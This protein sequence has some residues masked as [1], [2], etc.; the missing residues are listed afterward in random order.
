MNRLLREKSP[1]LRM[2]G[3]NPVDWYPWGDEAF[4]AARAQDMPVFL[5]IGYSS[6]HWCH[7]IAHESFEDEAV[8]AILNDGYISVKVDKEE[9]PDVDAV[10]M[11]AVQL[12]TGSGGW[13][14]TLL[15]T[16][17]G[18]PFF[19]AT[20][21][22][23][24]SRDGM[25][26]LKEL[27]LEVRALWQSNR[28]AILRA[29]G[30]FSLRMNELAER[31]VEP[32]E[33]S[34]AL[35][36]RAVRDFSDSYDGRWGGF[37]RAPKFPSAPNLLFL[38]LRGERAGDRTALSLA[39]GTLTAMYRGGLFD[40]VGGGFCRYSVDR[41][42]LIPHFEKMLYD[43]ALLLWAYAEA[44]RVTR[45]PVYRSV[46][47]R[48]AAYVLREMTGP[49]GE[50][51]CAQDADSAGREGAYY[52][53]TPDEIRSML[54]A[55]DGRRFCDWYGITS[56]G[57]FE[58]ESVP[59]LLGNA[60]FASEPDDLAQQRATVYARRR[61]RLPLNRDDKVLTAWNALM[62][63]A[64]CE[65][66][67]AL[68]RPDYRQAACRAEA[69]LRDH[70]V[71]DDGSLLLRYRDGEAR[72]EGVLSDSASYALALAELFEAT[73][74]RAYL[75]RAEAV[76]ADM[77]AHFGSREADGLYLYSDRGE[78]LITRPRDVWDAAMPS[79]NSCAAL[80]LWKLARHTG[81]PDW[82]RAADRQLRFV[83]GAADAH[84]T[85]YGFG[86]LAIV[87]ALQPCD[88]APVDRAARTMEER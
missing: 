1:Y 79:G 76:A 62:I 11:D 66:S 41:K 52:T 43:N 57:N 26:G 38:L 7:V 33:P 75:G 6:C 48:T 14:M 74:D 32:R 5:S 24:E 80:A 49:S 3:E 60:A 65:A 71:R 12:A 88:P 81:A 56:E 47:E 54:G 72:G 28:P 46:A 45:N 36:A 73:G 39:E 35:L 42:W 64:L 53:F 25:A 87:H 69:F 16:P 15:T 55:A 27:L 59:N 22:P 31:P 68:D 21:L 40:H 20:Y 83:A 2:H 13:P 86:L 63:A 10:Y 34:E 37:G 61:E 70:L 44:W 84:P 19:A 82:R 67:R 58:G 78:R 17:D 50:F 18:T 4:A 23:R 30:E 8:A 9:R 29:A 85:G 77:L 51:Y